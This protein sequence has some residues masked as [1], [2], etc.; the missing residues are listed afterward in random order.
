MDAVGVGDREL[1]EGLL[2]VR[3]DLS[4]DESAFGFAFGAAAEAAFFEAFSGA[5]VFDVAD[6]EPVRPPGMS[7]DSVI[8]LTRPG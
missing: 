6:R 2:P 5:F 3:G 4:F 1:G 7:G 8:C